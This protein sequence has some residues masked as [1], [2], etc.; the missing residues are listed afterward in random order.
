MDA[1]LD[2]LGMD[3]LVAVEIRS[4]FLK[5]LS[6]DVS[7]LEVLDSG[8]A[9]SLLQNVKET[10][11]ASMAL[12]SESSE[13]KSTA[14]EA[15][16]S[17]FTPTTSDPAQTEALLAETKVDS[18]SLETQSEST[19]SS[20]LLSLPEASTM[21][22]STNITTAPDTPIS[23]AVD[24]PISDSKSSIPEIILSKENTVRSLPLSFGQSRF[25]FLHQFLP[26]KSAFNITT[27]VRM[28]GHLD[29]D[30]LASSVDAVADHHEA[31]RTAFI[32][33]GNQ[34]VQSVLTTSPLQLE[35]KQINDADEVAH[36]Y[37]DVK[38]WV[39]DLEA[40]QTMRIVLL[41]L[42]PTVHFL[43]LGYHHINMDGL[44]FEVFFNDIQKAYQGTPFTAGVMQYPDFSIREHEEYRLGK[45]K[46]ELEFWRKEFTNLPETL[47]LLPLSRVSSRPAVAPYGTT[48][49]ERRV[50]SELSAQIK[51]TARK[52]KSGVFPF[53]LSVLKA[54][55]VRYLDID[56]LCIGLAD[57]NRRQSEVLEGIGLYL[58]LVPLRVSCDSMQPFSDSLKDMHRRSQLALSNARVPFDVLLNELGVS[59]SASHPPLFQVFMNYRQGIHEVREFCD[60]ECEG[61]LLGGGELAY[62]IS[63]DV[64]DNPSGE[65]NIMLHVQEALYDNASAGIL[66]DSFFNLLEAFASNPASRVNKPALYSKFDIGRALELGSGPT[67]ELTWPATLPQRIDE[68]A[69]AHP[70]KPALT[71]GSTKSLTYA[72]MGALVDIMAV[73]LDDAGAN[74]TVGVMQ[75]PTPAAICS[76]L[77]VMK[78]GRAFVPLDPRVGPARLAVIA[79]ESKPSCVLVD[80]STET[81][82]HLLPADTIVINVASLSHR[83]GRQVPISAQPSGLAAIIYTSGSTGTPKGICLSHASLRNNVEIF[84]QQF[85][86]VEGI[87]V[88]LQQTAFSFDMSLCQ[89]LCGLCTASNVVV[90]PRQ[91][92]GDSSALASLML[93]TGVTITLATP[94]EYVS[95]IRHGATD[96]KR[97]TAWKAACTGGDKATE[98][99]ADSFRSLGREDLVLINAYGPAEITFACVGTTVPYHQAG[100]EASVLPL[101]TWP[102]HAVYIMGE[103]LRPLPPGVPGEVCI[104]G[105]GVGLGYLNNAEQTAKA[106]LANAY[107]SDAFQAKGWTTLHRT[108]DR[109]RLTLDGGLILEGRINGDSQVKIRGI[110]IDLQEVELAIVRESRGIISDAA[111]SV[112]TNTTSST[113]YLV[114]HVVLNDVTVVGDGVV[115]LQSLQGRLGLPHYMKPSF[116][117]PVSAL[118][119]NASNKLDRQALRSLPVAS[120]TSTA[121]ARDES[122]DL[123]KIQRKISELWRQI[124]PGQLLSQ[125]EITPQTDF[126]HV[127]GTS[128]LLIELQALFREELG[129]AASVQDLFQASTLDAMASLVGGSSAEDVNESMDWEAEASLLPAEA[130]Q[131][132]S[133]TEEVINNPARTVVLT[134]ATGFL[135]RHILAR[136]LKNEEIHKVYCVAVRKPISELPGMFN[137]S[138]VEIFRGDLGLED[139]GLSAAD[140][141]RIFTT[142]DAIIH[143]GA[144]V[145]FMKTYQSI[146]RTNVEATKQLV[147]LSAQRRQRGRIPF[148]F[149]SSAAVTQLTPLDEFGEQS[150]AAYP[151]TAAADGYVTAKWVSERHLE[152]AAER[153][154][155]P[156]TVHRPSSITGNDDSDL[157]LMGNLFRFVERVGAVP[158]SPAWKGYFDLISVHSVAAAI[159]ASVVG[160]ALAPAEQQQQQE[161]PG[162][163]YQYEAG[164]ILY[165]LST[166]ADMMQAGQG[167]FAVGTLPLD[168]WVERAEEKGLNPLLA[169]YLRTAAAKNSRLAFPKLIK[170]SI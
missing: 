26:D 33:N 111:V 96:L 58:N 77:A 53:Y 7:V 13:S 131:A 103:D 11:V 44:S 106:F 78:S 114:A 10:V 154:G 104:A 47:P 8:T 163:R 162:V 50:P 71:D 113:D 68:I 76:I 1:P 57:A 70:N 5:E 102:N 126:F 150:V 117:V 100:L 20:G 140:T 31:L 83:Q 136:L 67:I 142:A 12:G 148:H 79:G 32:S 82:S 86:M 23:Q 87:E 135:G 99:L 134:G 159:V 61:E 124:I 112:R 52:F 151:P 90:A 84:T 2:E 118:P 121:S 165:P 88:M 64:I 49:V 153:H 152:H 22:L 169:A 168:Q 123:T 6:A 158:E 146:R 28:R 116:I 156:V 63:F 36:A 66:L 145:S 137:D 46:P 74:G 34:R 38:H 81:D 40:G 89:I 35:R 138:R 119:L 41:T 17:V 42:S 160:T 155:V 73:A 59:R 101:K 94:V 80:E 128:L 95:L 108:G 60:C 27:V 157:D 97:N 170:G 122:P 147:R 130:Y 109:G 144:D 45:W 149:V 75:Q 16:P 125:R 25:W 93:K 115:Y 4:W 15:P 56:D 132:Q 72:E 120:S 65:T 164:E 143:N 55:M 54:L 21:P 43:I 167:E 29:V 30:R 127:G 166:M 161:H 62:D 129:S 48:R 105:G 37:D 110:R 3:S 14:L 107:A 69:R 39:Y 19:H 92:R 139:L 133:G 18:D 141:D 98:L 51:N 85:G 9:T 91:V 24:E